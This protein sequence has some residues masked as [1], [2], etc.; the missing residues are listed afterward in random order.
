MHFARRLLLS[1]YHHATAGRRREDARA[2]HADKTEPVQILFYHR[3]ADGNPNPWTMDCQSFERQIDWLT[4]N[5]DV[6][7]LAEAQR[8]IRS[9]ANDRP[10]AV[11]TFDD[12]YA[13]NC[14]FALPLLL[15]RELPFVYYVTSGNVLSG[16]PF[17]HDVALGQPLEPNSAADIQA[18]AEA[19]IEIGA[20]TR[21]HADLG[22]VTTQQLHDEIVGSKID[23]EQMIGQLVCHFA[24]PFGQHQNLTQAAFR[25][26]H[27]AGF[28]TASSAYGG[29]NFPGG[30]AFHLERI[31]ADPE[32]LRVV[33][34]LEVDRR[35]IRHTQ[36]FDV[37]EALLQPV[38]D[39]AIDA[40]LPVLE[41]V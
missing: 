33:N 27:Q 13:E 34:W 31:H 9:G 30:D 16:E 41:G 36:S 14:D 1:A 6:V 38:V 24:F 40:T 23:L 12:G 15:D 32:L 11:V 25:I 18:L 39:H 4:E 5:F 20:H 10:T 29:Y 2:R 35:K 21:T 17:P 7:S 3:I 28:A 37:G 22:N 19:G 26:A 8:R